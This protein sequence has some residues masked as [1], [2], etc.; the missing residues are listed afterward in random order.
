MVTNISH[1]VMVII[2]TVVTE[3]TTTTTVPTSKVLTPAVDTRILALFKR[4]VDTVQEK[5]PM[6]DITDMDMVTVMD[7]DTAITEVKVLKVKIKVV[8]HAEPVLMST[9]DGLN[10]RTKMAAGYAVSNVTRV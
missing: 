7:M 3:D 2:I 8:R 4:A 5:P 9:M 1:M 10:A 6:E